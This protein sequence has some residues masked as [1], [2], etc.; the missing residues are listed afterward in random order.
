MGTIDINPLVLVQ[1]LPASNGLTKDDL[2]DS[3]WAHLVNIAINFVVGNIDKV[4]QRNVRQ[5][6]QL[7]CDNCVLQLDSDPLVLSHIAPDLQAALGR[8]HA[9]GRTKEPVQADVSF[10]ATRRGPCQP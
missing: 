6:V 9:V 7:N 3:S 2:Q 10:L 5:P 8:S 4:G 1:L